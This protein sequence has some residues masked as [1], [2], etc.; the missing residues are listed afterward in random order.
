MRNLTSLVFLILLLSSCASTKKVEYD[1]YYFSWDAYQIEK[2]HISG[3]VI[4]KQSHATIDGHLYTCHCTPE[5][6]EKN[7]KPNFPD[8]VLVKKV[9][10]GTG[11][12]M[13]Q[14]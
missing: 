9:T 10:K 12:T 7:Y 13:I 2:R 5:F 6:V 14:Y 1:Y 11:K 3:G 4:P 8:V